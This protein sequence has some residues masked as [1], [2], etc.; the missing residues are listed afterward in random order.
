MAANN[1]QYIKSIVKAYIRDAVSTQK[2]SIDTFIEA[3]EKSK[4]K[5]VTA[6]IIGIEKEKNSSNKK[7][8]NN[9]HEYTTIYEAYNLK[10]KPITLPV[11]FVQHYFAKDNENAVFNTLEMLLQVEKKIKGIKIELINLNNEKV[12]AEKYA[13][14]MGLVRSGNYK[15]L[16]AKD[17]K[18]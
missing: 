1:F 16:T 4:C 2:E 5:E 6:R 7:S 14:L 11:M 17:D 18:D 15:K 13:L 10:S 12:Y 8:Q 9:N 3:V